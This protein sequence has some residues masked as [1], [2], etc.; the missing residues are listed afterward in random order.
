MEGK[1]GDQGP[2]QDFCKGEAGGGP[3]PGRGVGFLLFLAF[4]CLPPVILSC[5]FSFFEEGIGQKEKGVLHPDG[6]T[7]HVFAGKCRLGTGLG[8]RIKADKASSCHN[9]SG[10]DAAA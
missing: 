7:P 6:R 9:Q 10:L 5:V 4:S 8:R 1:G 2:P 3:S